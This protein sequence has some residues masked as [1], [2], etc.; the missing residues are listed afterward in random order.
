[1][2]LF[3]FSSSKSLSK[4]KLNTL[5]H[6][7]TALSPQ[8]REYVKAAFSRFITGGISKAEAERTVRQLKLN[9]ADNLDA[10]EVERIKLK[11]LSF[12]T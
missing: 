6:Q 5:L 8:E 7:I 1:M 12:F 11:I 10:G 3:S 4:E 2:S 9:F